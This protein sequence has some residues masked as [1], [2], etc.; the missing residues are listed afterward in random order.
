MFS[1][2]LEEPMIEITNV[3]TPSNEE[4][5][6]V[7]LLIAGPTIKEGIVVDLMVTQM[8]EEVL[9]ELNPMVVELS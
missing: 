7:D 9:I 6:I 3:N 2:Y 4:R 1:N 5:M 8:H